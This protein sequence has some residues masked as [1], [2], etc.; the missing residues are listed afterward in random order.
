MTMM[1]QIRVT[2]PQHV[3]VGE[4]FH[5]KYTIT[6]TVDV[7]EFRAGNVPDAFE[8]LTG[9]YTSTQQNYQMI[10]GHTS[11]SSS[12]TYTYILSANKNGTFTIGGARAV[13]NGK[14]VSS[15]TVKITVSGKPQ[16]QQG[17]GASSQMRPAG[18]HVSGND[19]FIKVSA[20]KTHVY[21]QEPVLL[22]YKV[23]TQVNLSDV[24]GKMPDLTGFHVQEIPLPP[25]KSLH[26]E[27]LNGRTY[28]CVVLNQYVVY[29]QMTGKLE[30]PS[31][32]YKG[33]VVQEDVNVDPFEAFFN[34][35]SGYVKV[36]KEIVAPGMTLQVDPLPQKP[37]NFSGGVGN[38]TISATLDHNKVKAGD[39]VK[40][41]IVV[42]GNGNLKLIKQ[43]EL[44][45]PSDFD[46]YDAKVT[47]KTQLTS[48]GLS[49]NMLYDIL[50][51][52]RNQGKY[53]IQPVELTYF[54]TSTRKY[55]TIRT[56]P[57]VLDVEKGDGKSSA[58][59]NYSKMEDK[60]IHFIH[61]GATENVDTNGFFFG[62]GLYMILN[63]LVFIIF[64]ILL[65][66]FRKQAMEMA[67]IDAMRGKKANKVAGKKLKLAA[68]LM[69][70]GKSSAFY[71]EVLRALW[72]YVSD[73]LSMPVSELSRENIAEKLASRNASQ[74][75]INTF[76][77]AI[78]ECEFE[79]YAPGDVA[80]NMQKTY[81]KAVSAI[82][83]IE[84]GMKKKKSSASGAMS[85]LLMLLFVLG[86]SNVLMA[87]TTFGKDESAQSLKQKADEAYSKG[88]YQDA[89]IG[90]EEALKKCKSA[91]LYY[92]LG[93]AYYRT[94]NITRAI[95]NYEKAH[96]LAPGDADIEHNLSVARTKTIDNIQPQEKI[97][98][99]VWIE[100][101]KTSMGIDSWATMAFVSLIVALL[102]FL[103]YLF[104]KQM[105]VR[106]VAFYLSVLLVIV[107]VVG[108]VFASQL[109]DYVTNPSCAIITS[110]S[111]VTK[112]TPTPDAAD[113]CEL[114]E[115][116][117]V[118]ITDKALKGWYG[119]RLADGREGWISSES[120]E[121]IQ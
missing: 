100:D 38:F 70:E 43:P 30:I 81:D 41:R 45:V 33:S 87:Q 27:N 51:V 97:F 17:G 9:P 76:L 99:K 67:N 22:T 71:D 96:V 10:N 103:V 73:K 117:R 85:V 93:N 77:E 20:N 120:V 74:D 84:E 109:K 116:T 88:R 57:M 59:V 72:G 4:M 107:F 90:Y 63:A 104:A 55:K 8:I 1:A 35:G 50:I 11:Q 48:S 47:D 21:E 40:V 98:F 3:A 26:V 66:V 113:V 102:L 108:N 56:N 29:P 24:N 53:H 25:Q 28:R 36:T 39:P 112:K 49:G 13:V 89:V 19:L 62:S 37:A 68:K 58:V 101:V 91:A 31:F 52:P 42:G 65:I 15:P 82:T 106:K 92:N 18:S 95:I 83:N 60:D 23:Y 94:E 12:V 111:V 16:N 5:L 78:D 61:T 119:I 105:V 86:G 79:R 75:D 54:D 121:L 44:Q 118:D 34:G 14:T 64:I 80:G 46:K 114:H 110:P 2:A 32:P 7:R 115:G 6:S 69:A